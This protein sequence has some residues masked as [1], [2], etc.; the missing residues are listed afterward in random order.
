MNGTISWFAKHR[1]A[2]NLLM[3]FII[4]AGLISVATIRKETQP[5]FELNMI[6]VQVPYLG[7]APEEVEE[8][9]VVK[10]EEA[11]KNIQGVKEVRSTAADG[12]GQVRIEVQEGYELGDLTDEIKLAVDGISTFPAETERPVIAKQ[13]MRSGDELEQ[14]VGEQDKQRLVDHQ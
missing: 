7:A 5:E 9:V 12:F 13:I 2:A 8:G 14:S 4:V 6:Q 3:L 10:I 11:I 1:V